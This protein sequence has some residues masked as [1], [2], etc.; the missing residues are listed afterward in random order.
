MFSPEQIL[1]E[2]EKDRPYYE[3]TGG[4]VT[5]SGGEPTYQRAFFVAVVD[6]LH[7][8]GLNILLET[9]GFFSYPELKRSLQSIDCIYYDIKA[10]DP[11][12][13]ERLTGVGVETIH[14][15]LACLLAEHR[16][17]TIRYLVVPGFNDSDNDLNLLVEL[18][19]RHAV[20]QIVALRHHSLWAAKKLRLGMMDLMPETD[21][22]RE[23]TEQQ[24]QRARQQLLTR[25][26]ET[27]VE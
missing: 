14:R 13:H 2:V 20:H 22:L 21:S 1:A 7:S 17:V 25:G 27:V 18:L 26:I 6:L 11:D 15:N 24:L 4:G 3:E 12:K 9:N 23:E 16:S 8:R 10:V 5:L 19:R